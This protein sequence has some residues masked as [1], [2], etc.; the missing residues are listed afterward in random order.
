MTTTNK[1]F[2]FSVQVDHVLSVDEIWPEGNAPENPTAEDAYNEFLDCAH[3][4]C[5]GLQRWNIAP[6]KHD[7]WVTEVAEEV[8]DN[9]K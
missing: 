6:D 1:R 9:G 4:V 3:T 8:T 5:D 7:L 2:I